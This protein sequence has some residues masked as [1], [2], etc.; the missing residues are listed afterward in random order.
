MTT[1]EKIVFYFI[2]TQPVIDIMTSIMTISKMPVT[3][4]ALSRALLI[5]SLFFYI[6]LHLIKTKQYDYLTIWL[7]SF[8]TM[9]VTLIINLLLK[10]P[11]F[12]FAE[13][14]FILKTSYYVVLSFFILIVIDKYKNMYNTIYRAIPIVSLIIGGSFWIALI[15]NTNIS[16]YT[17]DKTGYSGWFFSANELSVIVLILLSLTIAHLHESHKKNTAIHFISLSFLLSILPMIGTKTAF[18]GGVIIVSMYAFYLLLFL[19]K[20]KEFISFKLTFFAIISLFFIIV[21]FTPIV[22]NTASVEL[23]DAYLQTKQLH[24]SEQQMIHPFLNRILS[25]RDI[26]LQ[27]TADDFYSSSFIQ[28]LFG[29]GYGGKYTTEPKLIEMDFFD[30]MFSY[31]Y[32]GFLILIIPL[33]IL[34]LKS[35]VVKRSI[36]LAILQLSVVLSLAISFLAG[37]ILLA[38][39]V[40]TYLA[41]LFLQTVQLYDVKLGE[42]L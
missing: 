22:S 32:I 2:I 23:N 12:L 36:S 34:I 19:R 9:L 27:M 40:M 11:F 25:S 6:T 20:K 38:P 26:Y 16:S 13:I 10:Q 4:G 42:R 24:Y 33:I 21:P 28:Q 29:I 41:V 7:C 30:L 14:N 37:H 17:Y 18:V 8:L 1:F 15:T 31:G 39:S 35:F 3:I 5:F